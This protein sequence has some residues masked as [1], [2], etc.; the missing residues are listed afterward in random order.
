M[1]NRAQQRNGDNT[2]G[3]RPPIADDLN[4]DGMDPEADSDELEAGGADDEDFDDDDEDED[5]DEAE[6][7]A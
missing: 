2:T 4:P 6:D 5:S 1:P 3:R 7:E